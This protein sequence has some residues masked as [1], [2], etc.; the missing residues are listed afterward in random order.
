MNIKDLEY[1]DCLC[2]EK[3]FTKASEKLFISQP[4][5]SFAI[6]R[7]ESELNS[8]LIIRNKYSKEVRITNEG[9]IF[10]KRVKNILSELN[11]AKV[12]L[13]KCKNKKIKLGMPPIIGTYFF[14]KFLSYFSNNEFFKNV[15]F[16]QCGSKKMKSILI[17]GS[18]DLALIGSL[19][20]ILNEH[21]VSKVLYVDHFVICIS[22]NNNILND[23]NLNFSKFNKSQFIVL[24]EENIH[25]SVIKKLFSDFNIKD[26]K[27][28]HVDEIQTAKSLIAANF[29]VGV[30]ANMAVEDS[31]E[32]VTKELIDPIPF[33]ISI[34][35]K[36]GHFLSELERKI[37]DIMIDGVNI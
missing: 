6:K 37:I 15:E 2:N 1:F 5:V 22:K 21:I 10:R 32:I 27:L 11:E 18:V 26:Y 14:P 9:L 8:K 3:S 31:V 33:Y 17:D 13:S 29:G 30:L 35:M 36:K 12:E 20:P 19:N 25:S 34:A 23:P 4:S 16:I 24:G 28:C 7:L